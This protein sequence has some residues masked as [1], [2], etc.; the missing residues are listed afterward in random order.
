MAKKGPSFLD[1]FICSKYSKLLQKQTKYIALNIA[2]KEC[3]EIT[4]FLAKNKKVI[5][6]GGKIQILLAPLLIQT[7]F[8]KF[9]NHFK[10]LTSLLD[11][12]QTLRT[13]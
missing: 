11:Q 10:M 7:F 8:F 13:Y 5:I 1:L 12:I 6:K 2:S 3:P 9:Q 4:I